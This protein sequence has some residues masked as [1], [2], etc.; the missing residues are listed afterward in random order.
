MYA[1]TYSV[2]KHRSGPWL[3]CFDSVLTEAFDDEVSHVHHAALRLV[4]Q[5]GTA[6]DTG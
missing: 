1:G 6:A 5:Q 4:A 2:F 3:M